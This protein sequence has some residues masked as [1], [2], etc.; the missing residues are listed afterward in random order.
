MSFKY[1]IN[2]ENLD[3]KQF[4]V[5]TTVRYIEVSVRHACDD[6]VA[7]PGNLLLRRNI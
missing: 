7:V 1:R 5:N 6:W 3:P 4:P 2:E